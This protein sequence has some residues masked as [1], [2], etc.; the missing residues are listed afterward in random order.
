MAASDDVTRPASPWTSSGHAYVTGNTDSS[1]FPTTPG[2]FQTSFSDCSPPT[3]DC[4]DPFVTKLNNRG[5]ALVYSTYLGAGG[6]FAE[7]IVVDALGDAYVVGSGGTLVT[8]L[9]P[10]GSALD[11]TTTLSA[12][13]LGIAID[14]LGNFYVTVPDVTGL[15]TTPGAFQTSSEGD[16]GD[17][18]LRSQVRKYSPRTA[19]QFNKY[20]GEPRHRRNNRSRSRPIPP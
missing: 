19:R 14:T 18:V 5:S 4:V 6:E 17:D 12:G 7:G 10:S 9:N 2:A 15:P 1:D 13:G 8:V 11:Y 20:R 3:G 16:E